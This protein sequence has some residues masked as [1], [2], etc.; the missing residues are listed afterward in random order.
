MPAPLAFDVS[1]RQ[2]PRAA[3]I[4]L[5]GE[6]NAAAESRLNAA[7]T[8][9]DQTDPELILLNF[10]QVD[11]M[12]ST[13]IALIVGLLARARKSK[14]RLVACGLTN[15]YREIFEITRLADYMPVFN[16]ESTALTEQAC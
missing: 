11:Y 3:I 13:G 5:R 15:H 10:A 6:I 2:Q 16:D 14:R 12:N 4:E 1:V 9:A 8:R 7:Y